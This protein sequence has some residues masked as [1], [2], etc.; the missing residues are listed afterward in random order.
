MKNFMLGF[1]TC[2]CIGFA[3]LQSYI[4]WCPESKKQRDIYI[5][6]QMILPYDGFVLKPIYNGPIFPLNDFPYI[7]QEK[8]QNESNKND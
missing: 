7:L 8:E 4:L 5:N 2:L 6:N 3:L 1:L